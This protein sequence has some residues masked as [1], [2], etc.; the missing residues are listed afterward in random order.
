MNR[1]Y[2]F[3]R[4]DIYKKSLIRLL[5]KAGGTAEDR[6]RRLSHYTGSAVRKQSG[7]GLL[8]CQGL[9]QHPVVFCAAALS[10]TL[11]AAQAQSLTGEA[12]VKALR[13]G[14]YIIV[15]RH[16]SSPM[17]TPDAKT[18]NPDNTNHERQL[19]EQGRATAVGMGKALRELKIPVGQ[20]LSSP[21][22][23]AMETVRLAQLGNPSPIA[24]LGDNGRGMQASTEAQ[25]AWLRSRVTQFPTGTNTFLVTHFPNMSRAFPQLTAS[26]ADGEALV[27]GPDGKGGATLVARVKIEEWPRMAR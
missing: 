6:R 27:F 17:Q 19:D 4:K 7:T 5:K 8:A 13:Q 16:A 22:Y 11:G 24:E 23:R 12:L 21:T 15:M 9:F 3:S 20:V 1:N 26:L 10:M 25:T 18:A 2:I 14:G